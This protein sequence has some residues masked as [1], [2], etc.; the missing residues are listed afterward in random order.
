MHPTGT[1]SEELRL[2]AAR[3][4]FALIRF[5]S[6]AAHP[7]RASRPPGAPQLGMDAFAFI[8]SWKEV[9]SRE[10]E[11]FLVGQPC[12]VLLAPTTIRG[13]IALLLLDELSGDRRR[14]AD[15]TF[16]NYAAVLDDVAGQ[17]ALSPQS[18][19]LVEFDDESHVFSLATVK[20][21]SQQFAVQV[22]WN[23]GPLP[24]DPRADAFMGLMRG[25]GLWYKGRS[26]MRPPPPNA[27][28]PGPP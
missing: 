8:P 7:L 5:E 25:D 23:L 9:P 4:A 14:W 13:S 1:D 3:L 6:A 2:A 19:I 21:W 10:V 24:N 16:S 22:G 26:C 27:P 12:P 18:R 15:K 20:E 17:L 28:G 11:G